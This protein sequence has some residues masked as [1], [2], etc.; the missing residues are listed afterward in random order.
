MNSDLH[1]IKDLFLEAVENHAP[2]QWPAFL[3][4]ACA[5]QPEVRRGVEVLL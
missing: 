3:D 2:E 1:R 4:R 5:G